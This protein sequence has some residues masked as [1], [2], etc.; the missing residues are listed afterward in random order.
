MDRSL[1]TTADR[2][3][4]H[5]TS[6]R[7]KTGRGHRGTYSRDTNVTFLKSERTRRKMFY[8]SRLESMNQKRKQLRNP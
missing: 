2:D 5:A 3:I 4:F 1:A 6:W 8:D 7:R